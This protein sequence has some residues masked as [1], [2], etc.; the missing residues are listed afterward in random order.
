M[1]GSSSS[2]SSIEELLIAF[3]IVSANE[4]LSDKS[5]FGSCRHRSRC[6]WTCESAP[7][8]QVTEQGEET[9]KFSTVGSQAFGELS[10]CLSY[11]LSALGLKIPNRTRELDL[12]KHEEPTCLK[13]S[14]GSPVASWISGNPVSLTSVVLI[15]LC[16][17]LL[18]LRCYPC[19]PCSPVGLCSS[20]YVAPVAWLSSTAEGGNVPGLFFIQGPLKNLFLYPSSQ[21]PFLS[22]EP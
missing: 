17:P 21:S 6:P 2:F 3:R 18:F 14:S 15:T 19:I 12:P 7:C 9:Q 20:P 22:S 4:S 1:N 8:S 5:T 10:V 16:L 13:T 11:V